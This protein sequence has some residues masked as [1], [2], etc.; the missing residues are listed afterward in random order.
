M[1]YQEAIAAVPHR[2]EC[3]VMQP[4][5]FGEGL[6][7]SCD[8]EARIAK[9]LQAAVETAHIVTDVDEWRDDILAAFL[10]A[11]T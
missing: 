11:A 2:A 8:R 1:T 6:D 3:E 4:L 5:N 7:C 10:A 9:G